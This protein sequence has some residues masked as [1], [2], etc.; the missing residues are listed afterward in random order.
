MTQHHR[1]QVAKTTLLPSCPWAWLTCAHATR[2]SF[3]GLPR[4]G[5]G[6]LC[7]GLEYHHSPMWQPRLGMPTW[8]L[9]VIWTMD[10]NKEPCCFMV[11]DIDMAL[12]S[13]MGQDV[14]KASGSI[15]GYSHQGFPLFI[16]LKPV[17]SSLPYL[18]PML[19]YHSGLCCGQA[20]W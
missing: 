10:I 11:M 20:V 3:I 14:T 9:G 2:V 17:F 18:H 16:A 4:Q 5:T 8:P 13:N 15:T 7:A 1:Q 6:L 19:T 12:R